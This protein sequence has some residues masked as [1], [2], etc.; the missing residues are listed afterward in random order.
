MRIKNIIF[1]FGGVLMDWNPIYLFQDVFQDEQ[2]LQYFLDHV[3][4][5][6]W[7]HQQDAGRSFSEATREL[8]GRYPEYE[9]EI[10]LFHSNWIDMI[11]GH[12]EQNSRL[13]KPLKPDYRLFGLTNWSAETFPLVYDEYPF[14]ADLEGIVVSG[15]EKIAKPDKRL[16]EILLN[17]YSLNANE[18]LFIDDNADNIEA[19]KALGFIT[20]H[21]PEGINLYDELHKLGIKINV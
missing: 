16:Y 12:I 19:A 1:D 14:F 3:C 8:I 9:K 10:N 13:I 15:V 6:E 7:N 17:R 11:G 4:N 20:I 18:S 21:L 2:R 5:F